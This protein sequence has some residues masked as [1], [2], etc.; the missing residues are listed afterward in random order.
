MMIVT[1]IVVLFCCYWIWSYEPFTNNQDMYKSF[2]L[3]ENVFFA[4]TM[5]IPAK[6]RF[7]ADLPPESY[8]APQGF[9]YSDKNA[10]TQT[11]ATTS[12]FEDF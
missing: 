8:P 3:G 7:P 1:I 11:Q 4:D 9:A 6:P 10:I 5:S 2:E 12:S